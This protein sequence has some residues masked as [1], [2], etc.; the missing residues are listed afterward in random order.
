MLVVDLWVPPGLLF[1]SLNSWPHSCGGRCS[2][3]RSRKGA[4]EPDLGA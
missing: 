2:F 1:M 4:K 3:L